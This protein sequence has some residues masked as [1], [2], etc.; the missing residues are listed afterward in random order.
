MTAEHL[1]R[2]VVVVVV[3]F[4]LLLLLFLLL[5]ASV[6]ASLAVALTAKNKFQLL[7]QD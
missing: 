6:H 2:A 1:S 4:L 3:F 5:S 7:L